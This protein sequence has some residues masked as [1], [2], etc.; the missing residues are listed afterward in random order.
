MNC[1]F[2]RMKREDVIDR[3]DDTVAF[4]LFVI[5]NAIFD[6]AVELNITALAAAQPSEQPSEATH[7]NHENGLSGG[8]IA[9]IVV[10]SVVLT[11]VI[12]A[13]AYIAYYYQRRRKINH[14]RFYQDA[15]NEES[16]VGSRRLRRFE[17]TG[18][19]PRPRLREGNY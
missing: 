8:A 14:D 17:D 12:V 18:A 15:V 16:S 10:G 4:N 11:I 5:S 13:L 1:T 6:V 7:L 3:A 19:I 9:G 2:V